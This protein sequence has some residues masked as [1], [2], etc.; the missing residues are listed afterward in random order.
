MLDKINNF[1]SSS[2]LLLSR[3]A[4]A[5]PDELGLFHASWVKCQHIPSTDNLYFSIFLKSWPLFG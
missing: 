4:G 1:D 3:T 2:L 5:F